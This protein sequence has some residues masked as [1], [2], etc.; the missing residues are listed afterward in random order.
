MW[1]SEME[2]IRDIECNL[3]DGV[4]GHLSMCGR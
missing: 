1:L 2:V 4:V 3:S